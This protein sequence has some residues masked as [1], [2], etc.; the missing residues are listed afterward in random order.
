MS[1]LINKVLAVLS[2]LF[3]SSTVLAQT[4]NKELYKKW[5]TIAESQEKDN[6]QGEIIQQKEKDSS[7][8]KEITV[9]SVISSMPILPVAMDDLRKYNVVAISYELLANAQRQCKKLKE[10]GYAAYIYLDSQEY[11]RVI[12]GSFNSEREAL[13]LR[14]CIFD[15]YPDTWILC[16]EDGQEE[17]YV[18]KRNPDNSYVYDVVEEMP[19]FPGGPSA[20]FDYLAESIKYPEVAEENGIQGRVI[21]TF[22]IEEDGSISNISIVKS[23]DPALDAEAIRVVASMPRWIPGKQ[24]GSSVRVKYT[25]PVTFRLHV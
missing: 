3:L 24:Q 5:K 21:L 16:L 9:E 20:L 18:Q 4:T 12:A 19:Q 25:V 2:F 7:E 1:H 13:H 23:V 10:N 14:E 8:R 6:N 22:V 17:R 11:Y 15:T